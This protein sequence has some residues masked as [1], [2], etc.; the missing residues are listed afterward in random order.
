MTKH[1][2]DQIRI[3]K[4][5]ETPDAGPDCIL[6]NDA[7]YDAAVY[8]VGIMQKTEDGMKHVPV[9]EYA[10]SPYD[11]NKFGPEFTARQIS[12]DHAGTIIGA[13]A[14]AAANIYSCSVA[15]TESVSEPSLTGDELKVAM[16]A[17]RKE[18]RDCIARAIDSA[19]ETMSALEA[20]ALDDNIAN[21]GELTDAVISMKRTE[22]TLRRIQ[23]W[24]KAIDEREGE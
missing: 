9:G 4:D 8:G 5:E 19:H 1:I 3:A 22:L 21:G 6:T 2:A 20:A 17:R 7:A 12:K 13:L 14:E 24:Q 16:A 18:S 23:N 10:S 11:V 15:L